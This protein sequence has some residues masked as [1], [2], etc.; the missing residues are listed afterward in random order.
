MSCCSNNKG[1]HGKGCNTSHYHTHEQYAQTGSQTAPLP[2]CPSQEAYQD[3]SGGTCCDSDDDGGESGSQP[4]NSHNKSWHIAGLDCPACVKK[5]E[6]ALIRVSGVLKAQVSFSTLRLQVEF[7]AGH[8]NIAGVEAAI[9]ELGFSLSSIDQEPPVPAPSPGFLKKYSTVITLAA[10][11][12]LGSVVKG[13]NPGAGNLMLILACVWGLLPI[14]RQAWT[15]ARSGTPFGIETL[16]TVAAIGALALGETIEAGMVLLLFMIGEE[17]EGLAA[18][19]ARKGVQGLMALTPDKAVRITIGPEGE[20]K[21]T[22]LAS[23]LSPGDV[24]EVL[25][26]D[27]L[28]ADAELLTGIASFDESALTG[29]SVP[30]DRSTGE[31]VMAG[32]LSADR[33]ARLKVISESGHNAIDRILKL[34]EEAEEHKAPIERFV[35]RFSRW[36]TPLM[37]VISALVILIPPLLFGGGWETWIYRGLAMLL[38]ACPCALVIS[39]PAAVTSGLARAARQ[40]FLIK[41]GAALEQLGHIRQVAFDKTGTLTEGR[42]EVVDMVM[43]SRSGLL[44]ADRNNILALAA[45][46]ETGSRHPLAQAVVRYAGRQGVTVPQADSITAQ[47]GKGVTGVVNGQ[48]I[49]VGSPVHLADS[50][51]REP[52]AEGRVFEFEKQGCTVIAVV[53]E[54]RLAG[55]LAISDTLRE[56]AALAIRHLKKLGVN[57]TMLTG[58]APIP[59]PQK[60]SPVKLVLNSRQVCCLQ[61]RSLLFGKCRPGLPWPWWVMVSMMPQP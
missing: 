5:A 36:Y 49:V 50:I 31:A 32:C 61:T 3:D 29:E 56:D 45:A 59:V 14:A 22:V 26:G 16:M 8:I 13:I 51:A 48:N 46:V 12:G 41:G 27:R 11:M 1:S 58:D 42:P 34:I 38:I 17:L 19:R 2:S 21:E 39:T 18:S 9:D 7:A 52:E 47:A 4:Q 33:V 30:V 55:L 20:Q 28:P 10:L 15:Q 43:F 23:Q 37:M 60:T 25:P 35:D 53:C 57:S 54:Q 6:N 44:D 40:G 24:I